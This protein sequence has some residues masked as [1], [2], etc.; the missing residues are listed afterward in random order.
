M[1]VHIHCAFRQFLQ[2]PSMG[3]ALRVSPYGVLKFAPGEFLPRFASPKSRFQ[4][5]LSMLIISVVLWS[6]TLLE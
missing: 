1:Y 3:F 4:Q 5:T 6:K 2:N